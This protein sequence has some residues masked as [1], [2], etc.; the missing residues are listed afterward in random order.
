MAFQLG[1]GG[2]PPTLH[3]RLCLLLQ[4]QYV[5]ACHC[6]NYNIALKT[7]TNVLKNTLLVT[8][9]GRAMEQSP[10]ALNMPLAM[11]Q[12]FL[13]LRIKLVMTKPE[14]SIIEYLFVPFL[15]NSPLKLLHPNFTLLF[16]KLFIFKTSV[17]DWKKAVALY[18]IR[19]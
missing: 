5:L 14:A 16:Q 7:K 4:S 10:P 2:G 13:G 6:C 17:N 18:V 3:L 8:Q 12:T 15:I 1:E 19:T 11:S 9:R